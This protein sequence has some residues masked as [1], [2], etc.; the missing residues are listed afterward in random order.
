MSSLRRPVASLVTALLAVPAWLV[1][2]ALALHP[3]AASSAGTVFLSTVPSIPGVTFD[4]QGVAVTTDGSGSA[5]LS[6]GNINGVASSVRLAGNAV[7]GGSTV[8]IDRIVPG[9]HVPHESHLSVGLDVTSPVVIQLLKADSHI[10]P[11]HVRQL[12]LHSITGQKFAIDPRRQVHVNLQSRK[13]HF[14][15]GSLQAQP[16]T[17]A[18][19]GVQADPGIAVTTSGPRFDPYGHG[20]WVVRLAPV[21]GTVRIK[22]V[23]STPDVQFDL[24]GT[25]LT[26]GPDGTAVG[27][28]AN[29]N[30]VKDNLRLASSDAGDNVVS[31]LRVSKVPSHAQHERQVVAAIDVRRYVQLHF[32]DSRGTPVR[33]SLITQIGLSTGSGVLTT[34]VGSEVTAP[35]LLLTQVA[36]RVGTEWGSRPVTYALSSVRIA[37]ANAVFTGRQRFAPLTDGAAWTIHLAV[38]QMELTVRDALFG[39]RIA[40]RTVITRPDHTRMSTDVSSKAPRVISGMVRGLYTVQID[41]AVVGGTT[42]VLVSRD[43]PI[44]LRVITLL[45]TL[46]IA[47][48]GA[49]LLPAVVVLGIVVAR[50]RRAPRTSG[51]DG[52]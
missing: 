47:L 7:P 19:E 27:P 31:G 12:Q 25:S 24:N 29:L 38:F 23:P 34:L 11:S 33:S 49:I 43:E 50:R 17:W 9:G 36:S 2:C 14:V 44:E 10:P 32:I 28:L 20:T 42:S 40:T 46:V 8:R 26:T 37:G 35:V 39:A 5:S 6:L 41:S 13:I 52:G 21:A 1:L 30:N 51:S 16:V 48:A 15:H 45:D 22:T 18:V 3:A 4:V